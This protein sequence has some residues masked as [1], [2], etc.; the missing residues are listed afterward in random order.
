[1]IG[2]RGLRRAIV[3]FVATGLFAGAAGAAEIPKGR[4]LETVSCVADPKQT[5]ALYL[6]TNFDAGRTWPVLFCF[7]PGARGRAPVERFQA[8]AE[9]FGWVVAGSNNS[10][11]GPW[12]ANVAAINAMMTDVTRHL[13]VDRQRMYAAGLSG[14]ARVAC[15]VA[16]GGVV[17]GVIACSAGFPG[18]EPPDRVPFPFFGTAG[19]TDFNYRELRRIDRELEQRKAVHRVVI[20]DGG[21]EWL[22]STLAVD[23]LAWFELQA[24]RS[25]VKPKDGG[26]IQAQFDARVKALPAQ[27]VFE[28][29]RELKS[30]VADFKGLVDTAEVEQELG[31]LTA[32][33]E[34][35]QAQKN[36]R[37]ADRTEQKWM[38]DVLSAANDGFNAAARKTVAELQAKARSS[39]PERALAM[40]VLAGLGSSSGEAAREALRTQ[41]YETAAAF[42]EVVVLVRP[43]R[44]QGYFD[45]ARARA[46]L[47]EKDATIAALERAVAAGF[48]DARRVAEEK[49]FDRMRTDPAFV[50][51]VE[52]MK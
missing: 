47:R 26:W 23:A 13:P 5:Y 11:N 46:G 49:L 45:L 36:D 44:S 39:T 51:V 29:Q 43:E 41:E 52:R 37:A 17:K 27:D 34:F 2:P 32:S 14:G 28:R 21:H 6:P 42:L 4:V 38:E 40:R 18:S 12:D 15:Q 20:F 50:A 1:M 7:D 9:K 48:K 16:I 25:G 31:R 8:A 35:K 3:C 19:E 10:R 30:V 33:A 24:M 22:S